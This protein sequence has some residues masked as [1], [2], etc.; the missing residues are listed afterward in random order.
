MHPNVNNHVWLI[1][2]RALIFSSFSFSIFFF[3]YDVILTKPGKPGKKKKIILI[4]LKLKKLTN[5]S[6]E[7][8]VRDDD[9][10]DDR[11]ERFSGGLG[12]GEGG[13]A[14]D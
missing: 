3:V 6:V 12:G 7:F 5:A 1:Q 4:R 13:E 8:L 2:V 10:D 14:R 11:N 9:D